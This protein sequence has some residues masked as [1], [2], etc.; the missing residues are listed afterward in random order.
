[1]HSSIALMCSYFLHQ[2][3][4]L[5]QRLEEMERLN[6]DMTV[7]YEQQLKNVQEEVSL[8]KVQHYFHVCLY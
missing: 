8:P 1:M 2:L 3:G 6:H 5:C 7:E 4:R